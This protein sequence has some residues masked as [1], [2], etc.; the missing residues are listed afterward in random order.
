MLDC[1]EE[2]R[3]E[4]EHNSWT[5]R[6]LELSSAEYAGQLPVERC[7]ISVC[8]SSLLLDPVAVAGMNTAHHAGSRRW[9]RHRGRRAGRRRWKR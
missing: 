1:S 9:W 3:K 5:Q 4:G 2:G 7:R 8:L 6:Q